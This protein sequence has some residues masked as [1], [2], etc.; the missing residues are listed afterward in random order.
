[1]TRLWPEGE[2]V[3]AWSEGERPVAF[4]W[5]S[6]LHRVQDVCNRWRIHACW[7][8]P[9][10]AIWREYYKVVTDRGLLCLIYRDLLSGGWFLSR[11]YD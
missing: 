10:R 3:E 1:M 9:E 6:E 7:W 4:R 2:R 11:I 8:E 5:H